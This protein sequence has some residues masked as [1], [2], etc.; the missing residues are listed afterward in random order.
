MKELTGDKVIILDLN[1]GEKELRSSD[2]LYNLYNEWLQDNDFA[3]E[4]ENKTV[5]DLDDYEKEEI[6]TMEFI[7]DYHYLVF[8][9]IDAGLY[10]LTEFEI[11]AKEL[12]NDK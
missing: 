9:S 4:S 11:L 12:E 2:D 5:D 10:E 3:L 6:E 1:S 8:E 7:R